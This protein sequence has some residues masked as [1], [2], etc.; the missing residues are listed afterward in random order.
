MIDDLVLTNARIV[1]VDAVIAGTLVVR[2]GKVAEIAAG[3]S[4]LPDA[5]DVGG[6][7]LLPGLVELHTDNLERQFSP[8]VGVRWPADAAMLAHDAQVAAAGITTVG[9]AV[10]VGFYGGKSERVG[11][12]KDSLDVLRRA[13]EADHLLHLRLE[14]LADPHVVE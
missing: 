6:D 12:L 1:A 9:D 8:R 3:P 13:R 4:R 5:V 2:G 10:C 7:W 11:Y 14:Q